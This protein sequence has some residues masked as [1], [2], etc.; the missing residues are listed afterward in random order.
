M[1]RFLLHTLEFWQYLSCLQKE[2][3]VLWCF[4]ACTA[5]H[6]LFPLNKQMIWKIKT[7]S[8]IFHSEL[9]Y[10]LPA[11]SAYNVERTP[12]SGILVE[13]FSSSSA[14]LCS[15]RRAVLWGLSLKMKVTMVE[16]QVS[17]KRWT[18]KTGIKEW[19]YQWNDRTQ[20]GEAGNGSKE[21]TLPW[22]AWY[23]AEISS[24]FI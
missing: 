19:K 1:L 8:W 12:P 6:N 9:I 7:Q 3:A 22:E 24:D 14:A 10:L 20:V 4:K 16:N 21:G 17:S 15:G 2:M 18:R 5:W 11:V 23:L 13:Q